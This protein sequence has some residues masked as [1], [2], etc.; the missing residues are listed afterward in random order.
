MYQNYGWKFILT[1]FLLVGSLLA[2]YFNGLSYGLDLS[3]GTEIIYS[4]DSHG[5]PLTSKLADDVVQ[6]LTERIDK[7]GIKELSIARLGNHQ[8][9]IQVPNAT[10]NEV[11]KIRSQIERSGRLEFKIVEHELD[12]DQRARQISRVVEEKRRRIWKE[13]DKYDTAFD[14]KVGEEGAYQLLLNRNAKGEEQ[15][16]DGDLLADAYRTIDNNG[17]ACVGFTWNSKGTQRFRNLTRKYKGKQLAVVL[18]GELHSAPVIRSEIGKKGIIEGGD[19]GWDRAELSNLIVTL[20]SG[21]LPAKPIYAYRKQVGAQLGRAA[22][23]IGGASIAGA[24]AVIILFM[25]WYYGMRCGLVANIALVLNIILILGTLALFE[26]TL[27]L[28]GIAGILLT[29][30]MAVDANILI[31]ERIREELARGSA[32]KQAVQAGYDRAFWTIFDANLT[33]SLTAVILMYV[34]T[35]PIKGFG[36]TLTVGIL[37]SMFTALF[38]TRAIYGMFVSNG[39]IAEVKFRQLFKRPD[40]DFIGAWPKALTVSIGVIAIGWIV[41]CMRG[42]EKYGIDFTGGTALHMRLKSPESKAEVRAKLDAHFTKLQQS[43]EID[44]LPS[45]SIQR[46]G[47][48]VGSGAEERSQEWLVRTNTVRKEGEDAKEETKDEEEVGSL[49]QDLSPLGT[50]Y[51]Q[52]GDPAP[53]DT[54]T[55]AA[56]DSATPSAPD[57]ATP[58]APDSQTAAKPPVEE[59]GTV[60]EDEAE[61]EVSGGDDFFRVEVEKAFADD[62]V[63]AEAK[64]VALDQGDRDAVTLWINLVGLLPEGIA[65]AAEPAKVTVE[66]VAKDLPLVL[67][68]MRND[69][70][71]GARDANKRAILAG[72]LGADANSRGYKVRVVPPAEAGDQGEGVT[73]IEVTYTVPDIP[74]DREFA[75]MAMIDAFNKAKDSAAKSLFAPA[76]AF[77]NVDEIGSTVAKNLKSKALVATLFSVM[78]ICLYVWLRFDLWSGIAAIMAVAHDVLALLGFLAILDFLITKAGLNYDVKFSLTTISAFLTLVGYSINDTIVILDRIRE[79]K[80]LAKQKDYSA[81]LING[82][83]N[84]TLSRTV[85][86][87]LT[88]FL[89]CFVLF[90]GSFAGLTAIQGLSVALLFG[91]GVGTYSSIFI[92]APILL[93]DKTKVRRTG[94]LLG[95]FLAVVGIL[96][97]V[98]G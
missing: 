6:V 18:D 21:A 60:I 20:K 54:A 13:T 70:E 73:T 3:G 7:L 83:V 63:R 56:P 92:A 45:L 4:L 24:L 57:S 78:C 10:E 40:L 98:L 47:E 37:S 48:N 50:A 94:A 14:P 82:A 68:E 71:K 16:V 65:G 5:K 23:R 27:T 36:L 44:Q 62:L 51:G 85:L 49:W 69:L 15:F 90:L 29:A 32:L 66:G 46:V 11:K 95:V 8:V 53:V 80:R 72:F 33:T 61:E 96:S 91:V 34:G 97:T 28:P 9:V 22:V 87:S 17:L 81:E 76:F 42:P 74:A 64:Y 43:G 59:A 25:F 93:A 89:V 26:A 86:T 79:D 58:S 12:Q 67:E 39:V 84:K 77:P 2:W 1:G 55:P 31:Y 41:F 88:S 38:V 30:G 35:G 52:E 75:R 19:D